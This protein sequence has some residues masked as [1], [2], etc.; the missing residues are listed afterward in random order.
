MRILVCGGRDY[1]D[2]ETMFR[3]LSKLRPCFLIEGG[4]IGADCLAYRWAKRNL[5]LG[6]DW[7]RIEADW[8]AHG[9]SAGPMRNQRMLDEGKPHL[10][11]AFPGGKGTADMVRRAKRAGVDV[12]EVIK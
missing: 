3:I 9:K 7:L 10:V 8:S 2:E 12:L 5:D 11:L 1:D 6:S 4:A